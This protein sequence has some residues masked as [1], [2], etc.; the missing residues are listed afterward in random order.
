MPAVQSEMQLTVTRALGGSV[1]KTTAAA[2]AVK[3]SNR[4]VEIEED[5]RDTR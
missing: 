4:V 3:P 5:D 1:K 2:H